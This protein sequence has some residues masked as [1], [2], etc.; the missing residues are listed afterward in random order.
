MT[1][2]GWK[3]LEMG[4]MAENCWQLLEMAEKAGNGRKW[5]GNAGFRWRWLDWL[6]MAM[7]MLLNMKR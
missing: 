6:N 5:L 3:W 7:K 2:N 4:G 1:G